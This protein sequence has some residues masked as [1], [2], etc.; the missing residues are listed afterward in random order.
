MS[1]NNVSLIIFDLDGVL[2]DS[3]EMHYKTLNDAL[4]DY[5]MPT[6]GWDEHLTK[7]DGLPTTQKL[8]LLNK[9]K[10][11]PSNLFDAIWKKKQEYTI[12]EMA[13][14]KPDFELGG[15]FIDLRQQGYHI[16]VASNSIRKTITVALASL[17]L[18]PYVDFIQSNED[19]KRGKPYPEM[20]WNC[21]KAFGAIPSNTIIVED[22]HIGRQGAIDSGARL[23]AV[24]NRKSWNE[25]DLYAFIASNAKKKSLIPWRDSKLNVVIPM[26]GAGSRFAAA[27]YTF[28]KPLIEVRGKPMIKVVVDNLNVEAHFIFVVQKEHYEKYHLK[29]MLNLIAPGCDIA[30]IDGMT[31]GAARTVLHAVPYIQDYDA[32]LLIANSDQFVEW[33]SNNTLYAFNAGGVDAGIVTFNATHPKW[34]YVSL[35]ENGWV[36]K[37]AEKEVISDLATVGI[38]YW[39]HGRDFI[40]CANTMF[41]KNIRVNNEFYVAP[42]FNEAIE[43]GLKI[44]TKNADKMWGIG[45]PESLEIFLKNG[46]DV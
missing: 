19:V 16:A 11:V 33:D 18:L 21:M 9:T 14:L 24:E 41:D 15:L 22:S 38:Y 30:V 34:S 29:S 28:P 26:A 13:N 31:D 1:N 35:D 46:P 8:Q 37:V 32:P 2:I 4:R 5:G 27:G 17:D 25:D 3:R 44:R 40:E 36:N 12:R 7:Y 23:F 42:V 43:K 39:K 6:I 10:N 45:D 20:Y